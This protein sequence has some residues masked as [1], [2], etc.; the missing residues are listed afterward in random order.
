MGSA[1]SKTKHFP[2]FERNLPSLEGKN[3]AITGCTSGT[4]LITAKCAARKGASAII[5][6][7]RQSGRAQAAEDAVK[8]EAGEG[9]K[10][11]TVPCDLQSFASVEEA[12]A[13]IKKK[14]SK[15]DVLCNNAGVMALELS[16]IHI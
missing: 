11:E 12:A 7:N 15:I 4:G 3:V 6:L 1:E 2:E 9:S 16:L 10:V 14:Y 5:M 13:T 8:A